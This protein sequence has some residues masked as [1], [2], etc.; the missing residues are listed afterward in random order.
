MNGNGIS[1]EIKSCFVSECKNQVYDDD[2]MEI[3]VNHPALEV[4]NNSIMIRNIQQH[5][6]VDEEM[7]RT[8]QTNPDRFPIK[9]I[10]GRPIICYLL[11]L[12]KPNQWKIAL[13]SQLNNV[14]IQWYNETLGHCGINRLYESIHQHFYIPGLRQK[15]DA[16]HY[17]M[18]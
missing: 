7:N 9:F 3:F 18:C 11:D 17:E 13:P 6:F 4:M 16:Y 10:Q 12:I 14:T 5:Q 15:F 2:I 8:Q 1:D